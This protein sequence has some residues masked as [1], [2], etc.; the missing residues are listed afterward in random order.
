MR[1][2][3]TCHIPSDPP[4][5][6]FM[7]S[8]WFCNIDKKGRWIRGILGLLLIGVEAW[9]WFGLNETFWSIGLFGV[10]LFALFEAIRGW[11]ALRALGIKTNF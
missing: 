2:K 8:S 5:S 1:L 7:A 6:P 11:C 9:L 10:G 4:Q 3:L